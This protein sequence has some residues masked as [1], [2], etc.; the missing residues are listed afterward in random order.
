MKILI[1]GLSLFV[2]IKALSSL[3]FPGKMQLLFSLFRPI[4]VRNRAGLHAYGSESIGKFSN[5][6][7]TQLNV[8]KFWSQYFA[9]L[10]LWPAKSIL[11]KMFTQC[12]EFGWCSR[13]QALLFEKNKLQ[14]NTE[15]IGTNL[16]SQK[17]KTRKLVCPFYTGGCMAIWILT[18]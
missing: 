14:F 10:R 12:F 13:Y 5:T 18:R 15:S 7:P 3:H 17:P 1:I 6:I 2:R 9:V 4:L 16:K 8:K 11:E